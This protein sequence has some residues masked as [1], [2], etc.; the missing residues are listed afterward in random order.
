MGLGERALGSVNSQPLGQFCSG[1]NTVSTVGRVR[2]PPGVSASQ[3]GF[4]DGNSTARATEAQ[5]GV[6]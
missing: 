5:R 3:A 6:T 2:C 4:L 1:S